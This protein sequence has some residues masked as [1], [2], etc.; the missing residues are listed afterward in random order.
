MS[1]QTTQANNAPFVIIIASLVMAVAAFAVASVGYARTPDA[2]EPTSR[3]TCSTYVYNIAPAGPGL[4]M[5]MRTV[6]NAANYAAGRSP[7][8]VVAVDQ[9]ALDD[10]GVVDLVVDATQHTM[11]FEMNPKSDGPHE[12][13]VG[14][15]AST[16][17]IATELRDA[18]PCTAIATEEA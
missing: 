7:L 6:L 10:E 17:A 2:V 5:E 11:G 18:I 4:E 9:S 15:L 16:S 8:R 14:P 13:L 1:T 12:I 3:W